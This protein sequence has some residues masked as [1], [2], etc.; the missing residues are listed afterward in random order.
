MHFVSAYLYFVHNVV[1]LYPKNDKITALGSNIGTAR[2][3]MKRFK[4]GPIYDTNLKKSDI[5]KK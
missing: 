5:I 3:Q 2:A 1:L 4:K